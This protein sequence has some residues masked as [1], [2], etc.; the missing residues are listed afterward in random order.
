MDLHSRTLYMC[1]D[2]FYLRCFFVF[3]FLLLF[4]GK[5]TVETLGKLSKFPEIKN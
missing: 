4:L 3:C 2:F 1:S 5:V